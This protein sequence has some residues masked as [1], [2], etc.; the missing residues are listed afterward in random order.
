MQ[1]KGLVMRVFI[2]FILVKLYIV[3]NKKDFVIK[4]DIYIRYIDNVFVLTD[5]KER[6]SKVYFKQL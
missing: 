6:L 2:F 1:Y 3:D 5:C 4:F